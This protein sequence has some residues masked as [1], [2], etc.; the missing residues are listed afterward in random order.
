MGITGYI[1]YKASDMYFRVV[2]E[3]ASNRLVDAFDYIL[4]TYN[5]I[6]WNGYSRLLNLRSSWYVGRH[7]TT[8]KNSLDY[9]NELCAQS[10]SVGWTDRSGIVNIKAI[11]DEAVTHIHNNDIIIRDSISDFSMSP[12]TKVY[13]EL[14][15]QADYN[16]IT[17]TYDVVYAVDRIEE[18]AFPDVYEKEP[19]GE[20]ELSTSASSIPFQKNLLY[21]PDVIVSVY[22]EMGNQLEVGDV[23]RGYW[24]TANLY[25]P[26]GVLEE[27]LSSD[28]IS[29]F[30]EGTIH[31]MSASGNPLF[32]TLYLNNMVDFPWYAEAN[33]YSYYA[34]VRCD[35][36]DIKKVDP[37]VTLVYKWKSFVQG[38]DS[39]PDAK[40]IWNTCKVGWNQTKT[41][42]K[43]S[44]DRST[45]TWM[46]DQGAF[47][48]DPEYYGTGWEGH[49]YYQFF[50]KAI[51]WVTKQKYLIKY[52][53]PITE[54]T[55]VMELMDN[56]Q[57]HDQILTG[58]TQSNE[59]VYLK[60]WITGLT[61]DPSKDRIDVEL[62]AEIEY[63]N[64]PVIVGDGDIWER[65]I[66]N[67]DIIEDQNN[68][69]NIIETGR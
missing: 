3:N 64:K 47:I 25:T 54:D 57:F 40:D 42:N 18:D 11:E 13:N 26:S 37:N 52:S 66:N 61:V 44:P 53:V 58:F 19:S 27:S 29:L 12:L 39:Y 62:T 46:I 50:R 7:I 35:A 15:I 31:S 30:F 55:V 8:Q 9:I 20:I 32:T 16:G 6:T 10:W 59:E 34:I 65:S 67:I 17:E 49:G 22:V 69:D 68:V 38:I 1:D 36:K 4:T 56:V 48:N 14:T 60:G 28:G 5:G 24:K 51:S 45:L 21:S 33:T 63:F 23:V 2:G 41:I 43:Y